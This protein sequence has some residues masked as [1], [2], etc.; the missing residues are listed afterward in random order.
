MSPPESS[1]PCTN[2]IPPAQWSSDPSDRGRA[3]RRRGGR[4]RTPPESPP[5]LE[6]ARRTRSRRK[7]AKEPPPHPPEAEHRPP[8]SSWAKWTCE[9]LWL[10]VLFFSLT[11][12]SSDDIGYVPTPPTTDPEQ[13]VPPQG[14]PEWFGPR[15]PRDSLH[16]DHR[17]NTSTYNDVLA[18][19]DEFGDFVDISSYSTFRK[20]ITPGL[21][22]ASSTNP[23]PGVGFRWTCS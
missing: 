9:C 3:G 1:W 22:P 8:V 10:L 14:S 11:L 5:P 16:I 12:L 13:L 7:I 2:A 23:G 4:P 18:N 21:D 20:A 19:A 6:R 15:S 17:P